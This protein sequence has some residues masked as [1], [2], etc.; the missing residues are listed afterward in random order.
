M[1]YQHTN[2]IQKRYKQFPSYL[3]KFLEYKKSILISLSK[4]ANKLK[5]GF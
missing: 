1:K 2:K 4:M 5:K 3:R